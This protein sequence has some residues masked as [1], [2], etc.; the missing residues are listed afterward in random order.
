[1]TLINDSHITDTAQTILLGY[2]NGTIVARKF[3]GA[4]REL[5]VG[6]VRKNF[7][8]HLLPDC[9]EHWSPPGLNVNFYSE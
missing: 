2:A 3:V 8:D 1:M 6:V 9:A 4:L 7:Q 5:E